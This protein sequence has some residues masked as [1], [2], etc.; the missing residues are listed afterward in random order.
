VCCGWLVLSG[1]REAGGYG[2]LKMKVGS[3]VVGFD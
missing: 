2:L 3:W 1:L